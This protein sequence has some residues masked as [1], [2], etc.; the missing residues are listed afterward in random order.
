MQLP[1]RTQLAIVPHIVLARD[2]E[3]SHVHAFELCLPHAGPDMNDIPRLQG[4]TPA[5]SGPCYEPD[6][7]DA[8][9]MSG[10]LDELAVSKEDYARS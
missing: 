10:S 9:L 3:P 5:R 8:T 1:F 2:G 4:R 7:Q 6:V